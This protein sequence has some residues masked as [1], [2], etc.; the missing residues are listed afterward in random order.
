MSLSRIRC[1]LEK[2]TETQSASGEVTRSWSVFATPWADFQPVGAREVFRAQQISADAT[3]K[4]MILFRK[5]TTSKMRLLVPQQ[6]T[7]LSAGIN[8]SVTTIP[9]TAA[10][11]GDLSSNYQ[12]YI[13]TELM[14]VSGG[15]Q[16]TSLTVT[17]GSDSTT[18]AEHSVSATVAR[19][20]VFN[21][22]S[23]RDLTGKRM[24]L[25]L[26]LSEVKGA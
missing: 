12:I 22:E 10:L 13:D 23:A 16:T 15:H 11:S 7:T 6:W 8:N 2:A 1:I 24:E 19:M 18:K 3:Y 26:L 4:A 14:N 21:V 17:R 25:E 9:V 20:A 5:N